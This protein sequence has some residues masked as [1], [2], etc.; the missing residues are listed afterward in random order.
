MTEEEDLINEYYLDVFKFERLDSLTVTYKKEYKSKTVFVKATIDHRSVLLSKLKLVDL[1]CD[2]D[3]TSIS[4]E[5]KHKNETMRQGDGFT[6][7]V[8][9]VCGEDL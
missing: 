4:V 6:Y 1:N 9:S 8:C 5:C 7:S 2:A 3:I